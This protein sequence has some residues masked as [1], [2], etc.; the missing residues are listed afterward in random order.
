MIFRN[1]IFAPAPADPS[2]RTGTTIG[3]TGSGVTFTVSAQPAITGISPSS[4]TIGSS[5]TVTGS[6]F[7][8]TQT[9]STINFNGVNATVTSWSNSQIVATVPTGTVSGPVGVTVAGF[10]TEGSVFTVTTVSHLTD[11]LGNQTTYT[12]DN[13][14]GAWNI[15]QVQGSGCSSCTIRGNSQLT[16]DTTGDVL[17]S[18]DAN[19]NATSYTYDTSANM[20]SQSGQS[21]AGTVTTSYTY[22]SLGEVLTM[23]DPLGNVTTNTYDAKGNLLTVTTPKPDANTAASVTQFGY[24]LK[25]ELTTITDP[26][27]NVT[28][29]AYTSTGL[30]QSI[31]DAQNHVTSYTYDARGNR[32]SVIDPINGSTHPTTFS[33]D[34]MNRLTGVTYPDNSSVSFGYDTRGRRTSV[35]DQ[36]NRTTNYVYDDADR[37]TSVTDATNHVTTYNYDTESNLTSITDANNNTTSFTYDANGRVTKTTFPSTLYETY[38]YDAVGNLTSKTD[39]KTQTIQYVYDAIN[40]LTQKTYPDSTNLDYVYDL[41]GKI[42]QVTDPTGTYSFAYDNMGRLIGT[43]T[44]YTFLPSSPFTNAYTYDAASNR[45]SL[46]AP[47]GSITTYGYDTLN[48]LNGMANS[49]AGSFG[50]S[51]DALSRRTQL[52]RPN[53]IN[54][55]YA[56]DSVSHL[57]S[58]LHQS[59]STTLD[60]ASYIYDNAG[61]RTSKTN[62]LN[63][64]TEGYTYDLIY[65]L[66]QVTQG[67]STTESYTYD[68]VGNRLSSSNVPTYNYNLSNQLTSNSNGSYTYDANGNTLTDPSGK[69][70]T[71]DFEN[72]LVQAVVPGT[73]TTT[74]KYDPF[75]RRI[76]KSGPLGTTNYLY[77]GGS[78][79]EEMDSAGN[80]LADYAQGSGVDEP[81]AELRSGA[82]SYYEL[83]G[84]GTVTSL[85]GSSG[86]I[87]NS[88]TYDSFGNTTATSG[89]V[90]NPY[91]YTARDYDAETG[92]QY[93]RARY[94]SSDLGRFLSEDPIKFEGGPSFFVYVGNHPSSFSDPTGLQGE[95]VGTGTQIGPGSKQYNCAA[96][97]L[98]LNWVW[99]T[100][101]DFKNPNKIFPHFGCNQITCSTPVNCKARA[102]VAVF[103]DSANSGNWHV[104][105]Q[106]CDKGWTSKYGQEPLYDQIKDPMADYISV[107][108]PKGKV[109]ETCWSCPVTPSFVLPQSPD[110]LYQHP[111]SGTAH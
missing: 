34:I 9:S 36:N 10:T 92:L 98:G 19:N 81:L 60:G 110:I 21:A 65:Q 64:V 109:K 43:T 39:R 28:T 4:G 101:P 24:D 75:G 104:E 58:V 32:T 69:S 54:T 8:A 88:Y 105:R 100:T 76:Q 22:N 56:Y 7:G 61:N 33:Y 99:V 80:L 26:L 111:P 18:I 90:L 107:Y 50:F 23:T 46:T 96:W 94:Y 71:W 51:Y 52:T 77:D 14:G 37:L 93:S 84:L 2:N 30:I 5:V 45:K 91:R 38:G 78:T 87:S 66:T 31:T 74:F 108:H 12:F 47:D 13:V 41:A 49:W 53:G 29:L 102:K 67:S 62:Y 89:S 79:L 17:S 70:Y 63:N 1:L 106:T 20:L 42:K 57:L 73:G 82:E 83:D 6:G 72:R 11:S 55:N 3:V 40:R 68:A 95:Q 35:T 25:G 15:T 48:R 16:Y 85:T 97:G 103:E 44:Q 86:S 27:N 59:G